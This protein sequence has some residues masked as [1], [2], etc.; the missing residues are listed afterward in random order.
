MPLTNVSPKLTFTVQGG[1]DEGRLQEQLESG[2]QLTAM[3][4]AK[5]SNAKP[6]SVSTL[7]I[8]GS[9]QQVEYGS[10]KGQGELRWEGTSLVTR[11]KCAGYD[12]RA[13]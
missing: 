5:G 9:P 11:M 1:F 2:P 12:V 8:D 4:D 6:S 7:K 13:S 10:M 3:S